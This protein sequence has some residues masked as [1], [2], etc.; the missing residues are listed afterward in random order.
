M[1]T[2]T[3]EIRTVNNIPLVCF[4]SDILA[5]SSGRMRAAHHLVDVAHDAAT[6]RILG[7]EEG[8]S[9]IVLLR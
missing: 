5:P 2:L 8:F 4:E 7:G 9:M 3:Y 1:T 6:L